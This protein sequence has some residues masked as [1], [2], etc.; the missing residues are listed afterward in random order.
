MVI[1]FDAKRAFKNKTGLGN[2]SRM[3][4]G[5]VA[6]MYPDVECRLYSPSAD[7][8]FAKHFSGLGNVEVT[9]PAGMGR[10]FPHLW[11]SFVVSARLT[12]DG[13]DIFH[14]LSHEL[15]HFI[16]KRVKKMVTMHDLIVWRYPHLYKLFDRSV[17][18]AK[19]RHSCKIAD[20]VVAA[21]EQT[22]RDLQDFLHVPEQKI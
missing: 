13:V 10:L 6:G 19:M 3:L 15:P 1:G 5:G 20:I 17:Y 8:A 9:T 7:G 2:Y 14:G 18:R 16:P 11:R 22:K 12:C 21:S 4:V